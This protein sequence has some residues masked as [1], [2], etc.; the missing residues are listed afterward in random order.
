M[1]RSVLERPSLAASVFALIG[2]TLASFYLA[3][4]PPFV[5]HHEHHHFLRGLMLTPL[6]D[7]EALPREFWDF[8]Q[9]TRGHDRQLGLDDRTG[10]IFSAR[11][12]ERSDAALSITRDSAYGATFMIISMILAV[13][14]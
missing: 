11:A 6:G 7:G 14:S 1:W 9:K 5:L 4:Q 10:E 13:I 8:V 3:F 12:F 2:L